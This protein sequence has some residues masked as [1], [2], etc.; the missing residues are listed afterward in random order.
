MSGCLACG[1]LTATHVPT[2]RVTHSADLLRCRCGCG[3]YTDRRVV[4]SWH[5][6]TYQESAALIE[7][8]TYGSAT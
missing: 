8:H 4:R 5:C 2:L 7:G 6:S 1:R 3:L